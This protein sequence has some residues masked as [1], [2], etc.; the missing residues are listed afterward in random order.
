MI[1]ARSRLAVGA[2]GLLLLASCGGGDEP[3]ELRDGGTLR[4]AVSELPESFNPY[5]ATPSPAL[6][7]LLEPTRGSAVRLAD[8]GSWDVDERYAESVEITAT[9][10]F[11]VTVRLNPD[12]V[13]SDGTPIDTAD[14][15][16][17]VAA[18]TGAGGQL[19]SDGEPWRAV[20]GVDPGADAWTYAVRFNAPTADWPA[21]VYPGLPS[22]ATAAELYNDFSTGAP[23][24]SGP[25]AVE[26]V[27]REK[28]VVTLGRHPHWWGEEPTL[29]GVEFSVM[30]ADRQATAFA[31]GDLD[32]IDLPPTAIT[33]FADRDGVTLSVSPGREWS[34]LTLNAGRGP[35]AHPAVRQAVARAVDR[36]ALADAVGS[37]A[38][39]AGS[40]VAVPGQQG[41]ADTASDVLGHDLDAATELLASAGYTESKGR[42]VGSDGA[43][44]TLRYPVPEGN[45]PALERA[46]AVAA[47]LDDL[48]VDV[49]VEPRPAE[50]FFDDVVVALDFDLVS[51]LWSSDP[52]ATQA[53]VARSTPVDGPS[54]FTGLADPAVAHAGAA[55][56]AAADPDSFRAAARAYDEAV[57]ATA[58]IIPLVVEPQA[59]VADE[60]V[61]GLTARRFGVIDWTKV[62]FRVE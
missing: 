60:E 45:E 57:L 1:W 15:Q 30:D 39:A 61:V 16:A 55:L 32:A 10:P 42:W 20:A 47:D 43:P 2:A 9:E 62:G 27:D 23:P 58:T 50:T 29:D 37:K 5:R 25:F 36:Q 35:L 59:V 19:P 18:Q 3:V 48:G 22:E 33:E 11:T 13:W 52:F 41:Y 46:E 53:A 44:L 6:Q 24:T 40:V 38:A 51:F 4:L 12:A 26:S 28:G 56:L 7:T 31:E 14:M 54:N 49:D 17:F 34:H 21:L 8:D